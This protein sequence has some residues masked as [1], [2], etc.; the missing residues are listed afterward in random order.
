MPF[1]HNNERN[2]AICDSVDGLR[3]YCSLWNVRQRQILHVITY[4]WNIKNKMNEY[5]QM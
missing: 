1:D 3:E 2:F 5:N 4:M